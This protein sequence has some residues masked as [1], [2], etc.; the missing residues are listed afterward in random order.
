MTAWG[1]AGT[2]AA[3]AR[4][5]IEA[6]AI[7][8][9]REAAERERAAA[10]ARAG[11]N[12]SPRRRERPPRR[13]SASGDGG[14][15]RPRS[16]AART[17]AA[18]SKTLRSTRPPSRARSPAGSPPMA[19]ASRRRTSPVLPSSRRR[20]AIVVIPKKGALKLLQPVAAAA[21]LRI[22]QTT[23]SAYVIEVVAPRRF[24]PSEPRGVAV[25]ALRAVERE[26]LTIIGSHGLRGPRSRPI[27]SAASR[28]RRDHGRPSTTARWASSGSSCSSSTLP[29]LRGDQRAR[30]FRCRQDAPR[31]RRRRRCG[32]A[33]S[34]A[35]ALEGKGGEDGYCVT[36][37][38]LSYDTKRYDLKEHVKSVLVKSVLDG[39]RAASGASSCRTKP[40]RTSTGRARVRFR[41]LKDAEAA[42]KALHDTEL[43]GRNLSARVAPP[44]RERS[45]AMAR[46]HRRRPRRRRHP[47]PRRHRRRSRA[48]ADDTRRRRR[49]ARDVDWRVAGQARK[50]DRRG[51][52]AGVAPRTKRRRARGPR[53]ADC[54]LSS[55]RTVSASAA[56]QGLLLDR[57]HGLGERAAPSGLRRRHAPLAAA[58]APAPA[59]TPAPAPAAPE[60]TDPLALFMTRAR[61]YVDR[62]GALLGNDA[63]GVT[64]LPTPRK[65]L[66]ELCAAQYG[67]R[68][69]ERADS[70]H[71]WALVDGEQ[72]LASRRQAVEA[73]PA[74]AKRLQSRRAAAAARTP[75]RAPMTAS[76]RSSQN[77]STSR[78]SSD[79]IAAVEKYGSG[80]DYKRL[81][82][83]NIGA[84]VQGDPGPGVG[85]R[86]RRRR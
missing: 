36:I 63:P 27:D 69:E 38:N 71:P 78:S 18:A 4:Q 7:A 60:P 82:F 64:K 30:V 20:A 6:L 86:G 17:D 81:G 25:A 61:A 28:A 13:P 31:G 80:F 76:A 3:R 44:R 11:A 48:D 77:A 50:V 62:A 52:L 83:A 39:G 53:L 55:R 14:K 12:A 32:A 15:R 56:R 67:L 47:L 79:F 37:H 26:I 66:I 84:F 42:A 24:E 8:E 46:P 22:S 85:G 72:W 23:D 16:C 29:S 9:R 1:G 75:S 45:A 51:P 40:D 49:R 68:F 70:K 58:P 73:A 21:G 74:A 54:R 43:D 65:Q 2:P 57:G 59:T 33:A 19:A 41:F 10:A 34:P 35:A 5:R